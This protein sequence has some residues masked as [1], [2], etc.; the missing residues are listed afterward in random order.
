[1]MGGSF[2]LFLVNLIAASLYEGSIHN[3]SKASQFAPA[4]VTM[5]FLFNLIYA[6]TWGTVA[7]LIPTEIFPSEMR[8]QGNGF[9]ITGWA[10]GVGWTVLV[11]PIMFA[12]LKSR[13]YFLFAGLN[14]LWIP[15]V[16]FFYPETA[17]RSLESIE[18]MFSSKS[19]FY[20]K[21][22]AAYRAEGD[23]LAAHHLSVSNPPQVA[24]KIR[25]EQDQESI[26]HSEKAS[27]N[28]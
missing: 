6:A 1:L 25:D 8:A 15:I 5:L 22:E 26:E 9:G 13:T 12:H 2:G 17:D 11:N 7:F 18:A 3:P 16:Y 24:R 23:V 27:D 21:M 4:A 19:P 28:V 20:S 14:L 10:I